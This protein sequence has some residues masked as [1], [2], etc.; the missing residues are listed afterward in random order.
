MKKLLILGVVL[1]TPVM[2]AFG[3]TPQ[4]QPQK[5]FTFKVSQ[6]EVELIGEALGLLPFN[7]VAQLMNKLQ[8]QLN[9]QQ[10]PNLPV[11]PQAP[12]E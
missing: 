2:V 6:A 10:Q 1:L 12:K 11:A 3:Q 5:E 8:I 9:T 4:P 7:K